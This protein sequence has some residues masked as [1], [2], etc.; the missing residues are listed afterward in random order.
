LSKQPTELDTEPRRKPSRRLRPDAAALIARL[1][2][3]QLQ[4][5]YVKPVDSLAPEE[6]ARMKAAFFRG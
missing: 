4:E 1:R 3:E 2:R 5:L 6:L